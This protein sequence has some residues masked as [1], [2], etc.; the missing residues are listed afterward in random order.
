[1]PYISTIEQVVVDV[2][3]KGLY[4]KQ[5]DYLIDKLAMEDIFKL[6]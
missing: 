1:M 3:T 4:K 2:L 5:F 6:A